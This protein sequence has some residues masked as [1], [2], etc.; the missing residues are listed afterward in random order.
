MKT[1]VPALF[2]AGVLTLSLA[3]CGSGEEAPEPT[4]EATA[5]AA[6]ENGGTGL[7]DLLGSLGEST[8][9]A[10][11]YTLDVHMSAEDPDLGA[12][13]VDFL[14][15]VMDDPEAV[16]TTM[17]MPEMGEMLLELAS[18][19]GEDIGLTAEE[20]GTTVIITPVGGEMLISN[21]NGLQ[22]SGAAWVRGADDTGGMDPDEMFDTFFTLPCFF[23]F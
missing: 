19:S 16:Q 15:E 20:L 23:W 1:R 3:A 22:E 6:E 11:N 4:G 18:L 10:T 14:F 12:F 9:E 2:A 21:H 8:A 13:T 7:I 5:S 17:V